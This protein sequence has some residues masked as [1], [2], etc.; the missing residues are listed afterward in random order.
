MARAC[1]REECRRGAEKCA[2]VTAMRARNA[3]EVSGSNP[4]NEPLQSQTAAEIRILR[5]HEH[6]QARQY[7]ERHTGD[8]AA[9][10]GG[11]VRKPRAQ[12]EPAEDARPCA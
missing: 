7:L 5:Q 1:V 4:S 9:E 12:M 10:R 6:E 3:R 11:C 2:A 8:G